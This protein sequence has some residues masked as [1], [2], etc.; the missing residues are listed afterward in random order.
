VQN[1]MQS[2]LR[3]LSIHAENTRAAQSQIRDTDYANETASLARNQIIQ[4][5]SQSLL[6]QANQQPEIALTLLNG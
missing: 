3:N 6:S 5:A 1:A 4:Q 2:N